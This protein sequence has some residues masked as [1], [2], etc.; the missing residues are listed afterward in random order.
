MDIKILQI[1]IRGLSNNKL[2]LEDFLNN[3]NIDVAILSEIKMNNKSKINIKNYQI[4]TNFKTNNDDD[5][6]PSGG[7][8]ILIKKKFTVIA[9]ELDNYLPIEAIKIKI[10]N[11]KNTLS[12][13]SIYIPDSS[14]IGI[15]VLRSKFKNLLHEHHGVSNLIIAGDFNAHHSMWNLTDKIDDRGVAISELISDSDFLV[16]NNGDHTFFRMYAGTYYESAIDVTI[17]SPD[18]AGIVDWERLIATIG[19]D[20]LPIILTIHGPDYNLIKNTRRIVNHRKALINITKINP[21]H[22]FDIDDY[23]CEISRAISNASHNSNHQKY[24]GKPWWNDDLTKLWN[25]KK[26]KEILHNKMKDLYTAIELK[27]ATAKLRKN[28][29]KAKRDKWN[30]FIEDINPSM[31]PKEFWRR[32]NLL[33]S[34]KVR[35]RSTIINTSDKIMQFLHYNFKESSNQTSPINNITL[36]ANVPDITSYDEVV[37]LIH[38]SKNTAP[39]IN[40]ISNS[41]LKNLN[42]NHVKCITNHFNRSWRS[43]EVPASWKQFEVIAIRKPGKD[44]NLIE[45]Y[46][47]IAL[48]SCIGKLFERIMIDRLYCDIER[49]LPDNTFG[50][51]KGKCTADYITDLVSKI[52]HDQRNG[53]M[54]VAIVTDINKAFDAVNSNTL[55]DILKKHNIDYR[56]IQW[57]DELLKN[58]TYT[59]KSSNENYSINTS[60]GLP[61]GSVLSPILFNCYT[62]EIHRLASDKVKILQYADD[63]TII[64]SNKDFYSLQNLANTTIMKFVDILQHLK[65]SVNPAKCKV[66]DFNFPKTGK[67]VSIHMGSS[68][69]ENVVSAK[70]LGIIIDRN[71]NFDEHIRTVAGNCKLR[72]NCLKAFSK[73]KSGAHPIKL[74]SVF[75]AMV[76][77]KLIYS[78][79]SIPVSKK[80]VKRLQIIQNMGTRLCMGMT[81]TTP[82]PALNVESHTPPV[83]I[84]IEKHKANYIARQFHRGSNISINIKNGQSASHILNTYNNNKELFNK[85]PSVFNTPQCITNLSVETDMKEIVIKNNTNPLVLKKIAHETI[86]ERYKGD[87]ILYTDGSVSSSGNGIGIFNDRTK[88]SIAIRIKEDLCIKTIETAAIFMAME[89][90]KK[91]NANQITILTDSKSA[92]SSIRNTY[93]N[94]LDR[95]Y[96]QKILKIAMQNPNTKF[97]IQWIPSHVGIAGNENADRLADTTSPQPFTINLS[98]KIPLLDSKRIIKNTARFKWQLHYEANTETKAIRHKTI[99]EV[100]VP[101]IPWFRKISLNSSDTRRM[102]RIRSGHT[103]DKRFF[104]L[105]NVTDSSNCDVCGV[106]DDSF[107]IISTCTKFDN[108]RIK[109]NSIYNNSDLAG[110]LANKIFQTI[111]KYAIFSTK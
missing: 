34:K 80:Q 44:P 2:L 54:T 28:I 1:N 8:A 94:K 102:A 79:I 26:A 46:R 67:K 77:S 91:S 71:T 39:G 30:E 64:I 37:K 18:L 104:K 38:K 15:N 89:I 90:G 109:Y 56:Y 88:E 51:R 6:Y 84:C 45:N 13:V 24:T 50:F 70:I 10:T 111:G 63:I 16:R 49:I 75:N 97:C 96:E 42:E 99:I 59:F 25:V 60:D 61:Q 5:S 100:T 85:I 31:T 22:T 101:K 73:T 69:L 20:H 87:L 106:L 92:C 12:I 17:V 32:V 65:L 93:L 76:M 81:K 41:I 7:V 48:G 82:I 33:N 110:T 19:S 14:I 83:L 35:E 36:N 74:L 40:G 9:T 53:L 86:E 58:R 3:E 23:E 105:I 107:H 78:T 72:I 66:L 103:F 21:N 4:H 62:T 27:K 47:P 11:T 29:I 43:L 68:L 98:L 108:I 52:E 95:F 57:I 55:V